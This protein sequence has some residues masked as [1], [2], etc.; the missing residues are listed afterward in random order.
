M[1]RNDENENCENKR[2]S[3]RSR[4]NR[5]IAYEPGC[6]PGVSSVEARRSLRSCAGQQRATQAPGCTRGSGH[7]AG[8]RYH[9]YGAPNSINRGPVAIRQRTGRTCKGGR[10]LRNRRRLL[11]ST[12]G[13]THLQYPP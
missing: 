6:P 11:Q 1:Q 13:R 9:A 10:K 5:A 12:A 4:E 8:S 7:G 3:S 2:R